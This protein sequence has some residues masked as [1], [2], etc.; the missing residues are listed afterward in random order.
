MVLIGL[1]YKCHYLETQ[2][3]PSILIRVVKQ[4]LLNIERIDFKYDTSAVN[5]TSSLTFN[6]SKIVQLCK[7]LNDIIN[8]FIN[9]K[10][11]FF[12]FYTRYRKFECFRLYNHIWTIFP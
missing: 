2:K 6:L 4:D 1:I 8:L 12:I 11:F 9:F 10:S 7:S 3:F 5:L